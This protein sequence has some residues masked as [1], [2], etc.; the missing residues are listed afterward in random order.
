MSGQVGA[1]GE[2]EREKGWEGGRL[3]EAFRNV[4]RRRGRWNECLRRRGYK[5][6]QSLLHARGS[7]VD[8]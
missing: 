1:G 2:G 5:R 3:Y 7:M 6:T 4:E 8:I